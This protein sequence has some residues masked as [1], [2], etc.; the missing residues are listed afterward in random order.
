MINKLKESEKE[1]LINKYI[2]EGLTKKQAK[3][4]L[5]KVIN[6]LF[7]VKLSKLKNVTK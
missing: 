1:V 3:D 6:S 4:K 2:S 7:M 5:E